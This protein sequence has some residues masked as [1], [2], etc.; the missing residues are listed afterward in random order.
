MPKKA[1]DNPMRRRHKTKKAQFKRVQKITA[2]LR[3]DAI[4]CVP[5]VV[6]RPCIQLCNA[7]RCHIRKLAES[8]R[9]ASQPSQHVEDLV[10]PLILNTPEYLPGNNPQ[11]NKNVI[12]ENIV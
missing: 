7:C 3:K 8:R 5:G 9:E 4:R 10:E 1:C 11:M 6:W 2:S 12:S